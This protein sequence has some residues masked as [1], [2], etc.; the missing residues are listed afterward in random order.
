MP[1]NYSEGK[2]FHKKGTLI[3]KEYL[4]AFRLDEDSLIHSRRVI[5]NKII[6]KL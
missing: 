4:K 1:K 2:V 5:K 6:F 3:K